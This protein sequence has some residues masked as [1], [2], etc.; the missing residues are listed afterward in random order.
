LGITIT[1]IKGDAVKTITI[2]ALNIVMPSPHS[3]E[4]Y[5]ELFRRAYRNKQPVRLRG[6]FS[7]M[8]GALRVEEMDGQNIIVG[9]FYKF[10]DLKLD[11]Q[12]VVSG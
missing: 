7:G 9:E 8:L 12:S 1:T 2:S 5:V 11:G 4:R 3:A 6:D 10:L